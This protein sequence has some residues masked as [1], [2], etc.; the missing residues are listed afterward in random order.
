M[1]VVPAFLA[2]S[3]ALATPAAAEPV[4]IEEVRGLAFDKGIVKIEE[5]EL[6]TASGRSRAMTQA[7]MRSR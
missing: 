2:M 5:V 6:D 1:R 4:T 7:G 3:L